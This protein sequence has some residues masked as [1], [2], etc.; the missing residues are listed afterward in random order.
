MA[1]REK[2]LIASMGNVAASGGYYISCAADT[3]MAEPTTLTGS[4]GIFGL[5][6]SGEELIKDKIGLATS[7]VKTNEHSDFGGGY[8]LPIP[9][10]DRPMT[11]YEKGVMQAHIEQGYDTFLSRVS[12]GRGMS[13][14]DVHE[15]AQGRVWTGE[16][17]MKIGLVDV[18]GGLEDAVRLAAE[19]AGLENYRIA[20]L[21]AQ[22]N[23]FELILNNLS[24]SV[25][26]NVLRTELGGWYE[27][28]Q[29]HKALLTTQ[30]VMARIPYDIVFN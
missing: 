8:P 14:E 3:I 1:A 17:A 25:K 12:E 4:I 2:V 5:T 11:E 15:I 23:P 19:K 29:N 24:A 26:E 10:S 16:D 28:Y 20:E 6:M 18:F 13:K 7:T 27:W 22:K 9:V 30:G 21:P